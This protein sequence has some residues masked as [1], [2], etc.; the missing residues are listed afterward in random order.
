MGRKRSRRR[1]Q[2]K[3]VGG[4]VRNGSCRLWHEMSEGCRDP[5]QK[6]RF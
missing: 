6:H 1:E 2:Q 4:G 3:G 5:P